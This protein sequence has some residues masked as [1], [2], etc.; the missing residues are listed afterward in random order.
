[1]DPER[2]LVVVLLTNRVH[3]VVDNTY[4]ETRARFTAMIAEA[5]R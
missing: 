2:K 3:P 4:L 1:M 5:T